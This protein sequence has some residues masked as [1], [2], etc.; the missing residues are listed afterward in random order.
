[1]GREKEGKREKTGYLPIGKEYM[2]QGIVYLLE[3][4]DLLPLRKN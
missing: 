2:L 1:V 4:S 3:W